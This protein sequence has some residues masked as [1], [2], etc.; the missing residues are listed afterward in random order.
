MHVVWPAVDPWIGR[1]IL[2]HAWQGS[3]GLSGSVV[4]TMTID[5]QWLGEPD[6]QT[7]G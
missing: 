7:G 5:W 2:S 4:E 1:F 6:W 3:G